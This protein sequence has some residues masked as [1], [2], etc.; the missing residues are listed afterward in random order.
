MKRL[1]YAI[2][3][4]IVLL[5]LIAIACILGYVLILLWGDPAHLRKAVIKITQ[6]LLILSIFPLMRYLNIDKAHLGFAARSVFFKQLAQG[7]VL[8][9]AT[10]APVLWWLYH[11]D[12]LVWDEARIWTVPMLL[13][14]SFLELLLASLVAC[15]EEPLFRGIL[16]M[17]LWRKLPVQAAIALSAFYYAML[18]FLDSKA[19]VTPQDFNIFSGFELLQNALLNVF[20]PD[21]LSAQLALFMVGVFLAVIRTRVVSSLGLCIGC[22]A[23]WVWQIKMSKT[24]CNTDFTADYAFLV[25]HYNEVVGPLVAVWLA[26]AL[27]GY[28]WYQVQFSRQ[29]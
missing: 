4:M 8:G 6:L 5:I 23:S 9:F 20:N 14:K 16:L 1:G 19:S 15:T 17:G 27:L 26:L 12:V 13:K 7:F 18:H 28:G 10:L 21:M 2:A 3:P 24:L 29:A 25:G 11:L 22:H